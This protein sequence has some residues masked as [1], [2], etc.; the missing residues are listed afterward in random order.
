MSLE[1]DKPTKNNE[2]SDA[3]PDTPRTT[4]EMVEDTVELLKGEGERISKRAPAV[5]FAMVFM[6]YLV[7]LL[8]ILAGILFFAGFFGGPVE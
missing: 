4:K 7:V 3:T 2:N 5:P 6:S 8:I 1:N